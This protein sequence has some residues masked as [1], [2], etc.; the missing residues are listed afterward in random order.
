[1]ALIDLSPVVDKLDPLARIE[2]LLT[3]ILAALTPRPITI[4]QTELSPMD[5][6]KIRAAFPVLGSPPPSIRE[7]G[8]GYAIPAALAGAIPET[9]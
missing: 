7:Q 3:Q 5:L 8:I 2:D 6:E 1:M 4:E 9:P